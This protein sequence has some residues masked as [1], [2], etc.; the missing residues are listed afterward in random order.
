MKQ[1]YPTFI[2]NTNDD[3]EHQF[4]ICVPSTQDGA[5]EKV[6]QYTEDIDFSEGI[7]TYVDVDFNEYRR[8]VDT[9]TVSMSR[10]EE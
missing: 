2:V 4:L 8:K 6:K 9:K 7:L 1:V 3:S 10:L 5:I